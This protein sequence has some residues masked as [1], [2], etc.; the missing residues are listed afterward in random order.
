V[1]PPDS[2]IVGDLVVSDR[3]LSGCSSVQ[4]QEML[5]RRSAGMQQSW[6]VATRESSV[7][8]WV[9]WGPG[10]PDLVVGN[11]LMAG[12]WSWMIFEVPSNLSPSMIPS[13]CD[14]G[15]E[16]AAN[17]RSVGMQSRRS[18][19]NECQKF[20]TS[21]TWTIASTTGAL[22]CTHPPWSPI[23]VKLPRTLLPIGTQGNDMES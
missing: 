11:L 15:D 4:W 6:A 10:H 9:G 3:D 14:F 21:P 23:K 22:T 7:L 13:F 12:G 5:L 18:L 17:N 1:T 19:G 8:F 20:S 16:G 2:P